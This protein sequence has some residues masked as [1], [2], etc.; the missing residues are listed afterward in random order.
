MRR[1]GS[2]GHGALLRRSVALVVVGLVTMVM[3]LGIY[4]AGARDRTSI[5]HF[6]R[7]QQQAAAA[8]APRLCH[9]SRNAPAYDGKLR[10]GA[11]GVV[12]GGVLAVG[13]AAA[14]AVRSSW[15]ERS[16]PGRHRNRQQRATPPAV[17]RAS[18]HRSVPE[19]PADQA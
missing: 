15:A 2:I 18:R 3:G 13:G 6:N 16:R 8:S 17:D 7:C 10:A 1:S 11:I 5:E 12:A 19:P 9:L 4:A 14:L